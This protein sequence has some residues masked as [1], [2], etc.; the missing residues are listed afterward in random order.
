MEPDEELIEIAKRNLQANITPGT[1]VD[2]KNVAI[3]YTGEPFV[4]FFSG[5]TTTSGKTV[6]NIRGGAEHT[7]I[8]ALYLSALLERFEIGEYLLISDIEG[9]EAD[10]WFRDEKALERCG[11]IIVEL[12]ETEILSI[13]GQLKKIEALGFSKQYSYGRVFCFAK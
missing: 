10:I 2:F 11:A 13:S 4:D 6:G 8:K 9:A 1:A 5:E 7:T 12:E 3:S